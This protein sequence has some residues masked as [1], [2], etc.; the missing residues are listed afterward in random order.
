QRRPREGNMAGCCLL[1]TIRGNWPWQRDGLAGTARG[2]R[3]GWALCCVLDDRGR[4]LLCRSAARFC[5]DD[6]LWF[7]AP[8]GWPIARDTRDANFRIF[9][10]PHSPRQALCP[11]IMPPGLW[12]T[13]ICV[14][15]TAA[16]T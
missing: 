7:L 12:D 14:G 5:G 10:L 3:S 2:A 15:S 11:A 9:F 8:K 16:N 4:V 13:E 1:P 6:W